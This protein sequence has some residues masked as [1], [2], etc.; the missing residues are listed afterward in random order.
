MNDQLLQ[1]NIRSLRES[2]S[3]KLQRCITQLGA[4]A[5]R[6]EFL[7]GDGKVERLRR[8]AAPWVSDLKLVED[9]VIYISGRLDTLAATRDF[10]ARPLLKQFWISTPSVFQ[11]QAHA[12]RYPS[13]NNCGTWAWQM[14][15]NRPDADDH[16]KADVVRLGVVGPLF[17][18]CGKC[19]RGPSGVQWSKIPRGGFWLPLTAD[20]EPAP[21]LPFIKVA[22][23][24]RDHFVSF[25]ERDHD[26]ET[27]RIHN[28][29]GL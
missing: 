25:P 29:A 3:A 28:R 26:E 15:A 6:V 12:D 24:V 8:K 16:T 9:L 17:S 2:F 27:T 10:E 13:G 18:G 22:P 19:S 7:H 5:L 23:W 4:D 11:I 14:Q 20:R 21:L 1:S